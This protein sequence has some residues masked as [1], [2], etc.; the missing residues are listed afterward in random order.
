MKAKMHRAQESCAMALA[1]SVAEGPPGLWN[2]RS[3]HRGSVA[4]GRGAL[5]GVAWQ[6]PG[7]GG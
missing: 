7:A 4:G 5:T 6:C 2:C 1:G 3:S